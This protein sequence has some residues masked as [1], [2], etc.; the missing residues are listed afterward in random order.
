LVVAR[1]SVAPAWKEERLHESASG[2]SLKKVNLFTTNDVS[3]DAVEVPEVRGRTK[4]EPMEQGMMKDE[5]VAPI[6]D[7]CV[8]VVGLDLS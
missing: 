1:E 4:D 3:I 5:D 8:Y 7:V 6:N 2:V